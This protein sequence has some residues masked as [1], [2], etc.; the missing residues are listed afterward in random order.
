MRLAI[1]VAAIVAI[2]GTLAYASHREKRRDLDA[3]YREVNDR[4]FDGKLPHATL[5]YREGLPDDEMAAA[6]RQSDS[7]FLIYV[8]PDADLDY[9]LPH[10]ACHTLTFDE[11]AEHG[12]RWEACMRRFAHK[13]R[14]A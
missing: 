14:S 12:E 10:E 4:Y 13:R 2:C 9:V 5:Y 11:T 6:S 8:R 7:S 3:R 1:I